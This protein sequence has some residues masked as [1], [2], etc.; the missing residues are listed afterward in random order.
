MHR[1]RDLVGQVVHRC[2]RQQTHTAH[3]ARSEIASRSGHAAAGASARR[4]PG[5]NSTSSPPSRAA[6]RSRGCTPAAGACPVVKVDGSPD[7]P[8]MDR[9][10]DLPIRND[11]VSIHSP[12]AVSG[13]VDHDRE[14]SCQYCD[15][16]SSLRR[17]PLA[18]GAR[19]TRRAAWHLTLRSCARSVTGIRY[20]RRHG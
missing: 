20:A 2:R 3:G 7:S 4:P 10:R 8:P 14:H 12:A 11:K 15:E 1:H 19:A 18:V 6:Y 9:I 5:D 17:G 13:A 16:R